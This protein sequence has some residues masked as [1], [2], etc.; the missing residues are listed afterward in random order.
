MAHTL[1]YYLSFIQ[2]LHSQ[3]HTLQCLSKH[4]SKKDNDGQKLVTDRCRRQILRVAELQAEDYHMDRPLYYAC[5]DARERF[6]GEVNAGHGRIYSCLFKNK[7]DPTMPLPVS[8]T[9]DLNVVIFENSLD[10]Q[11]IPWKLV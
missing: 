11:Y 6:C 7:F 2:A 9:S 1:I 8:K 3:G 5:R 4:L 10:F